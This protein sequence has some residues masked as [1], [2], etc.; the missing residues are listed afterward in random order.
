MM[1]SYRQFLELI[2]L[3]SS[4]DLRCEDF[5]YED[6]YRKSP[7]LK[8]VAR[9]Y[10]DA[11]TIEDE[12]GSERFLKGLRLFVNPHAGDFAHLFLEKDDGDAIEAV[13]NM[14]TFFKQFAS[15]RSAD[16][17]SFAEYRKLFLIWWDLFPIGGGGVKAEFEDLANAVLETLEKILL[18]DCTVCKRSALKG[19]SIWY[20]SYPARVEDILG[21]CKGSIPPD[22]MDIFELARKGDVR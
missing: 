9:V 1:I 10:R 21:R 5:L 8:Y 11:D 14:Y 6:E 16:E 20:L 2:F 13:R 22:L 7:L 12:F 4:V 17:P 3:S 19:L 18:L 15:V